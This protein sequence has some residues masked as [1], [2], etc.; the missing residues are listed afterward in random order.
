MEKDYFIDMI[1]ESIETGEH[2]YLI[3]AINKR[4]LQDNSNLYKFNGYLKCVVDVRS[5]REFNADILKED[6]SNEIF[7]SPNGP[8]YTKIKD[9]APTYFSDDSKVENSII[10]SGCII[11]GSVKNSV[12]FRK[13]KIAKNAVVENSIIMQ[14]TSI[15]ENTYISNVLS[16]KNVTITSSKKLI[17]DF[18]MPIVVKK[19]EII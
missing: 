10:A 12:I 2:M 11:E 19:G 6:I 17:G 3:D 14:N 5:Y 8:I 15:E 18:N 9:E 13:V 16:D 1:Y 7:R 4:L